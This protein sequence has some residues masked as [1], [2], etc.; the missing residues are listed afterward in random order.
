MRCA[1]KRVVFFR[2][3]VI[4]DVIIMSNL[5]IQISVEFLDCIY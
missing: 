4:I 3:I 2:S 1:M 5:V